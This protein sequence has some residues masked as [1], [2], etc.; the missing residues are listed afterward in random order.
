MGLK[1]LGADVC[2]NGFTV[3]ETVK[4]VSVLVG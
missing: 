2:G 3:G 1:L 4:A